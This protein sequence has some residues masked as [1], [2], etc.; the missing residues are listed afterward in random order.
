VVTTRA[1]INKG[2]TWLGGQLGYSQSSNKLAASPTKNKSWG[3]T[4]NPAIGKAI[5]DNLV[6]GASANYQYSRGKS[7]STT[8]SKFSAYGG[9]VFIRKYIPVVSQL[10]LFGDA[11]VYAN[12]SIE[13]TYSSGAEGKNKLWDIGISATPGLAYAVT[14]SIQIETGISSL[15]SVRYQKRDS[16]QNYIDGKSN[17]FN[18]GVLLDSQNPIY[19]GFRFLINKKA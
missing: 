18:A 3:F 6:V 7:G 16:N 12:R 9:G 11:R 4:F 17:A 19:I 13:K 8:T 15:F 5:K 14:K 10:Y 2:A 1:Q